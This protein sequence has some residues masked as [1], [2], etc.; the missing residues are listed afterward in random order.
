MKGLRHILIFASL[1]CTMLLLDN[2]LEKQLP[3]E[4]YPAENCGVLTAPSH[5]V[6]REFTTKEINAPAGPRTITVISSV[7]SIS[8]LSS[9]MKKRDLST[10]HFPIFESHPARRSFYST[11]NIRI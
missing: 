6:P 1:V 5:H 2:L 11:G 7:P 8:S 10:I 9:G 3:Q 4:S